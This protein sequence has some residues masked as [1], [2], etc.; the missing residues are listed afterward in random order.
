MFTIPFENLTP[1]RAL[2]VAPT[3]NDHNSGTKSAPFKTIQAAVD[4]ATPGTEI[5]VAAGTYHENVKFNVSGTPSAPIWL[6][7]A[8]GTGAAKIVPGSGTPSATIEAFGEENIVINGFDVSGGSRLENGIQFGM[9]GHDFND[10]TRNIV[11]ENNIVHDTVKDNI[12]VSQGDYIYVIDNKTS[13]AGDQGVDFVDVN[14][15]VIARNDISYTKGPAAL[16]A[17][18]GSTNILI[19]ENKV[20]HASVDG[21]EVGGYS[22]MTWTRPADRGWEAKNVIV[23]NNEVD[24]VGKRPLNII[25]A[26]EVQI[27]HNLLHSNP[28]YYYVVTISADQTGHNSKNITF[29]NNVF[30]RSDHWLQLLSGQG[31][32]LKITGNHYD[33][34]WQGTVGPHG[35]AFNYDLP[36]LPAGNAVT[37][38]GAATTAAPATADH[39]GDPPA[40]DTHSQPATHDIVGTSASE[41]LVGTAGA[42]TIVGQGGVDTL[43]GGA[44]NDVYLL[45]G[46][47]HIIE[48]ANAGLDLV[49]S[50]QSYGLES[51][52]EKLQLMGKA[53]LDG[54]GNALSNHLIGNSANNH[55]AGGAGNDVLDGGSGN[56]TLVGGDGN[57]V[58]HGGNGNDRID[59]GAGNDHLSGGAGSDTFVLTPLSAH[60]VISDF[61]VGVDHLQINGPSAQTADVHIGPT[62]GGTLV[63]FNHGASHAVLTDVDPAHLIAAGVH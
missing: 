3:G 39:A 31:S 34:V 58:L 29:T 45:H 52:V 63:T 55:L 30:D 8:G 21:I 4:H 13:H 27:T 40:A 59:G 37:A 9:S 48:H 25:G 60:D 47:D 12:K 57:D 56:D 14:K 11:I 42:D 43:A 5:M 35:G 1:S 26:Q 6:T 54:T 17:K 41:H 51:N 50:W 15:S 28:N 10:P 36:W 62:S 49:E 7:S 46:H 16:F 20:S 44:G 18:G 32:G 22:D 19:A 38:A 53:D 33:G 23:A 24:S 2:W 61:Q